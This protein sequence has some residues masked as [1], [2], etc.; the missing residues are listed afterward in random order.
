MVTIHGINVHAKYVVS[1]SYKKDID[2]LYML[3]FK[4]RNV[5]F[6]Y[7]E[8][9]FLFLFFYWINNVGKNYVHS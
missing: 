6:S 4:K 8:L 9:F 1:K 5:L 2:D 3:T 7:E